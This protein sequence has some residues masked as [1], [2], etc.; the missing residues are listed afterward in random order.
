MH[1]FT[2]RRVFNIYLQKI[3]FSCI[4]DFTDNKTPNKGNRKDKVNKVPMF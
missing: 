2:N 1:K 4:L 3:P